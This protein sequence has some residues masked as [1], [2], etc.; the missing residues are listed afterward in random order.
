MSDREFKVAWDWCRNFII[1]RCIVRGDMPAKA[2]GKRYGWMLYLRRGL[3][4]PE[5]LEMVSEMLWRRILENVD[6][7]I[8]LSGPE[9]AAAPLLAGVGRAAL[10]HR[11]PLNTFI[12][13]AERKKYGLENWLEGEPNRFPVA[14]VDDLCNSSA[15]LAHA[16]RIARSE[17][18][19]M[20]NQAFVL[21]NKVNRAVH[22]LA[23]LVTDLYLPPSYVVHALY[24]L[25]DLGLSG[26]SH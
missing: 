21:V 7:P 9:T 13:R 19:A 24:T 17:G 6:T 23:R 11:V 8:Q 26:A 16:D 10:D 22:P 5:F 4:A 15:S 14:L 20:A 12:V 25:D 3:Y 1:S 2:P 18:L